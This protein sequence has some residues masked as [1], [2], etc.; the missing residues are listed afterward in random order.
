MVDFQVDSERLGVVNGPSLRQESPR[1]PDLDWKPAWPQRLSK[2]RVVLGIVGTVLAVGV[3][4]IAPEAGL[5]TT[6]GNIGGAVMIAGIAVYSLQTGGL[7]YIGRSWRIRRHV[8][9]TQG[10]GITIGGRRTTTTI[11]IALIGGAVYGLSAWLSWKSGAHDESLLPLARDNTTAATFALIF[12]VV[13]SAVVVFFAV[14]N[15]NQTVLLYPEGIGRS[16]KASF[17]GHRKEQFIAWDDIDTLT[18]A[19][20]RT[21]TGSAGFPLIE[22]DL[23]T[24]RES[25]QHKLFDKPDQTAIIAYLSASEPNTLLAILRHLHKNPTSRQL[26]AQPDAPSWFTPP[27][28]RVRIRVSRNTGLSEIRWQ[29]DEDNRNIHRSVSE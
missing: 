16:I 27:P 9:E 19:I 3:L 8:D 12:A 5:I 28:L 11:M 17:F 14:V 2:P 10:A 18:P 6:M 29:V 4:V 21:R 24:S 15:L 23:K 20:F 7:R 1:F 25:L 13:M 22:L 26:L